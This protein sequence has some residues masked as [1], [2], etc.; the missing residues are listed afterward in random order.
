MMLTEDIEFSIYHIIQGK[1]IAYC[2]KAMLFD[3]QPTKFS[4]SVHQ[5]LR[6]IKGYIQVFNRYG[7]E[8][9]TNMFK[10]SFL[11]LIWL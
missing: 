1:K 8:L 9:I 3:E 6:W 11:V 2:E 10:G 4:Q 5:R 7:K